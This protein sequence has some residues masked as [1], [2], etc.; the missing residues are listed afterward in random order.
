MVLDGVQWCSMEFDGVRWC[1]MVPNGFKAYFTGAGAVRKGVKQFKGLLRPFKN[2]TGKKE[3]GRSSAKS[4]ERSGI[5]R[6]MST[7]ALEFW[8]PT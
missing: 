3:P 5:Q 8:G 1:A 4:S 2:P 7:Y 6:S